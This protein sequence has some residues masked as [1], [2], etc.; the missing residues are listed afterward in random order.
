MKYT[1]KQSPLKQIDL[2]PFCEL[3]EDK[4]LYIN[5]A[6]SQTKLAVIA[7]EN[8]DLSRY[9][10][11]DSFEALERIN[12]GEA[13]KLINSLGKDPST[14]AF[15]YNG[16]TKKYH[17]FDNLFASFEEFNNLKLLKLLRQ[18]HKVAPIHTREK[19]ELIIE[20]IE[21]RVNSF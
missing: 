10:T 13:G 6:L 2:A 21:E 15:V 18:A 8:S 4:K 16:K 20:S 3:L 5:G 17:P 11:H 9:F 14:P 12:T 19:L 7:K 1:R